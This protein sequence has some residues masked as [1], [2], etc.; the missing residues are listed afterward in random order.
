[1]SD[2]GAVTYTPNAGFSGLDSF[3]YTVMDAGGN[4][5]TATITVAATPA[6]IQNAPQVPKGWNQRALMVYTAVKARALQAQMYVT[7]ASGLAVLGTYYSVN[8]LIQAANYGIGPLANNPAGLNK[9]KQYVAQLA[10][11]YNALSNKLSNLKTAYFLWT[12]NL[13]NAIRPQVLP[14]WIDS[15]K[16][17]YLPPLILPPAP[18]PG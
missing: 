14:R 3:S 12:F 5:S 17:P 1:M 9:A 13:S 11:A 4:V 7:Y 15:F 8:A 10:T 6:W 16:G 18:P 2:N